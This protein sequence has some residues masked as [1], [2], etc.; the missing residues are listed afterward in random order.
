MK[1]HN[2]HKQNKKRWVILTVLLAVVCVGCAELIACAWFAPATFER[3]TAPVKSAV[4]S[5]VERGQA[6]AA[7]LSVWYDE[8]RDRHSEVQVEPVN[9][10]DA[11][12][13]MLENT[14]P[15][16]DP[17][18]TELI[19]DGEHS[20]LTGGIVPVAYYNQGDAPWADEPYGSDDIGRYG[21][22]PTAMAMA[23]QSLTDEVIDPIRMAEESVDAGHWARKQGSYLSIV[24]GLAADYGLI[25]NELEEKTP[26]AIRDA[27]LS[28]K[29]LVALM[30][31]GHF[32]TGGHFILIRGI[33]L[34]GTVLV[35]DP[36]STERSLQEWD[37]QLILDE[38]S[39][40]ADHGA[41]L[42]TIA[43]A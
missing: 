41:P 4:T 3:I 34:Q 26:D 15:I 10:Q 30:G 27:L 1:L 16:L 24:E 18:I 39:D 28:G 37:P 7:A 29:L 22:G 11:S 12:E 36:N 25:A 17:A 23:I 14:A 40:S 35:A 42:W 38:L 32:T 43:A 8:Y 33:T 5:V 31:P 9:A 13:P 21:C 2:D 20:I 19:A 6:A